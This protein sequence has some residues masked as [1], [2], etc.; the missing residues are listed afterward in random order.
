MQSDQIQTRRRVSDEAPEQN[1]LAHA[2][3]RTVNVRNL[4]SEIPGKRRRA[5]PFNAM[6]PETK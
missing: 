5:W 3:S 4:S 1:R 6:T 2:L